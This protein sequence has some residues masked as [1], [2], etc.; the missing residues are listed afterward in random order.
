[1]KHAILFLFSEVIFA[2]TAQP[3]QP[4]SP[5]ATTNFQLIDDPN[6]PL[7]NSI[8]HNP[9]TNSYINGEV[10]DLTINRTVKSKVEEYLKKKFEQGRIYFD[11]Y[12]VLFISESK[13]TKIKEIVKNDD[14]FLETLG[15]STH[16]GK[17][18]YLIYYTYK[19][20]IKAGLKYYGL[21]TEMD[22]NF[23]VVME[24]DFIKCGK[25]NGFCSGIIHFSKVLE[26]NEKLIESGVRPW[27]IK[28]DLEK[29]GK[30]YKLV[31]IVTSKLGKGFG[32]NCYLD[33]E[34]YY[35]FDAFTGKLV[36]RGRNQIDY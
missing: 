32:K 15:D 35:K 24:H 17:T 29:F 16:K 30:S 4:L 10:L 28:L 1:M 25:T 7:E 5:G 13:N 21:R 33:D 18:T 14:Y 6:L 2:A 3:C 22:K 20:A 23:D 36:N 27:K 8:I 9:K 11:I 26:K 34:V 12:K 31:W 19:P